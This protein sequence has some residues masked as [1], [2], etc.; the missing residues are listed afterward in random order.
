MKKLRYISVQPATD[1]YA[2]QVEVMINNF[3]KNGINPNYIDIIYS[4]SNEKTPESWKILRNH[5]N[6]V[7]FFGYP[8]TRNSS[9]YISSVRPHILE[10]HFKEHPY[11][12]DEVIFYH[13]CD[14]I[15]T[16][17]PNWDHLLNDDIWYLS[18]TKFYISADY[19]KSKKYGIYER[20]CEIVDIDPTI[21]EKYN[22]TSSGGAQYIMKN[23][24]HTFWKKVYDDSE[25][26]YQFFLDHLKVFPQG[27]LG[28]Y[29]PIQKWTA[30]MWAVLWNAWYFEHDSKVVPEMDFAW[31]TQPIDRWEKHTIFH[32][33]GVN[34]D[35]E[36]MFFKGAYINKFPYD[37][38]LE[39]F[40][41][42]KCSY[43]YVKEILE[44]SKRSCLV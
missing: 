32:N 30:D 40:S 3:I 17:P 11:L 42:E 24:D 16:Q 6:T 36:D 34:N 14:M 33:A 27:C 4:I 10:K 5:Y 43:K 21:P 20:M 29:H 9:V 8:D 25:S 38:K 44:T 26:L 37:I 19:I 15:F 28:G 1:Y 18:D 2:W 7:R 35:K 31:P 23:I 13:D 12:S 41:G 39:Q 22:D